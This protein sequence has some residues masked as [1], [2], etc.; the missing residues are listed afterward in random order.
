MSA[1][2]AFIQ[3]IQTGDLMYIEKHLR[4][5]VSITYVVLVVRTDAAQLYTDICEF[6]QPSSRG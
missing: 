1:S 2:E 5:P 3:A 4:R 6:A